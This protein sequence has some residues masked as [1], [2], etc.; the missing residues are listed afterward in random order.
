MTCL[1]QL[2]LQTFL[3]DQ[4]TKG[5]LRTMLK[6]LSRMAH[7]DSLHEYAQKQSITQLK[8]YSHKVINEQ[9]KVL[10]R[11]VFRTPAAKILRTKGNDSSVQSHLTYPT[12]SQI[13]TYLSC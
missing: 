5:H 1:L 6:C 12:N 8:Y 10:Q 3:F 11:H 2:L 7:I 4:I 9:D 13:T